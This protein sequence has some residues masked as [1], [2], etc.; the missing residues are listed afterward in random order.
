MLKSLRFNLYAH[1]VTLPLLMALVAG[2]MMVNAI[3][4]DPEGPRNIQGY[5][6]GSTVAYV[7]MMPFLLMTFSLTN[8][9]RMAL[10]F[11]QTRREEFELPGDHTKSGKP[12]RYP[13]RFEHLNCC[14]A[15]R[16]IITF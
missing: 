16:V 15:D 12:E 8:M 1:R 11:G 13:F 3:Q 4:F 7:L 5:F 9:V 2:V 10:Q 14:G 6:F